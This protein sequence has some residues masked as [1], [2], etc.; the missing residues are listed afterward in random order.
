MV[1]LRRIGHLLLAI[2]SLAV[3]AFAATGVSAQTADQPGS[4]TQPPPA[5]QGQAVPQTWTQPTPALSLDDLAI[6]VVDMQEVRQRSTAVQDV[7]RQIQERRETYERELTELEREL[8]QD[9][10]DLLEQRSV[11][12]GEDYNAAVRDLEARLNEARRAM[13]ETKTDLDRLYSR[14]MLEVDRAIVAVAEELAVERRARLVLPKSGVLLVRNELDVTEEV[15]GRLNRRLPSL[16][17]AALQP[18]P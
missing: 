18:L 3:A 17:I 5:E 1:R 8:Q 13:R 11:M 6:L 7:R 12:S 2:C 14:G 15:I 10:R 16:D 4:A 9:Q